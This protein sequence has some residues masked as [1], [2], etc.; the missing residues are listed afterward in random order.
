M[1]ARR[2]A[3][4]LGVVLAGVV[5]VCLAGCA[6][7]SDATG[8]TTEDQATNS[9]AVVAETAV[10]PPT[11][12]PLPDG[13][14]LQTIDTTFQYGS[15]II[16]AGTY[17]YDPDDQQIRIGVRFNNISSGW[18]QTDTTSQL[19]QRDGSIVYLSGDLFEVPPGASVDVTLVGTALADA[20]SPDATIRW[21]SASFRQPTFQLDGSGGEDLWLPVDLG[22]RGWLQLGKFGIEVS[23]IELHASTID[24]GFQAP[25]GKR[26]IR[27]HVESYTSR[28]NTSPFD[29]RG[30]LLLRLPDG[31]E[32][33]ATDGA[34]V[35]HQLSWTATGGHWADFIVPDDVEGAYELLLGSVPKVGFS[36]FRPE[37]IVRRGLRFEVGDIA[38][39]EVV[40]SEPLAVPAMGDSIGEGFGPAFDEELDAGSINV[41]GYDFRPT[42]L[43]YEPATQTAELTAVV[44]PLEQDTSEGGDDS[45]AGIASDLLSAA[46]TFSD[47]VALV[48]GGRIALGTVSDGG[49]LDPSEPTELTFTMSMVRTLHLSDVGVYVGPGEG[50]VSSMPI[51]PESNV[52]LWP[53]APQERSIEAPEITVGPW[54]VRLVSY[55][56]GLVDT[57]HR[58]RPGRRQLEVALDATAASDATS[59]ALGLSFYGHQQLLLASETGYDQG[60]VTDSGL[61]EWSPGETKRMTVTFDVADTFGAG[62]VPFVVRSRAEFGQ[63]TENWLETRFVAE[64]TSSDSNEGFS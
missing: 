56:I 42:A 36:T 22:V 13:V 57:I 21:G 12:P 9:D 62:R 47:R 27:A 48:S 19:E 34:V 30:N 16:T 20:P 5:T 23:A 17:F 28:G 35:G 31:T 55:R 11:Q 40:A 4:R 37:A 7:G 51:G 1:I 3:V 41:A 6:A 24:L 58:A 38:A 49:E 44:T 15:F 45:A 54:T 50:A 60:A 46:P 33:D 59:G 53:P 32:I 26:V 25:P 14:E 43:S 39:D 18:A 61:A 52:V 10:S 2:A 29:P 64:L 8:Q 63:I